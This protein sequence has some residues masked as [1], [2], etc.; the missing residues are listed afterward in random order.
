MFGFGGSN[1]S[2]T[3]TPTQPPT[4][5]FEDQVPTLREFLREYNRISE[6]C[7]NDCINDFSG[8][9]GVSSAEGLCVGF[10]LEKFLKV[11]QRISQRFQEHQMLMNE[12]QMIVGKKTGLFK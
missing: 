7:F 5:S 11:T 2:A 10:C 6:V 1:K 9:A 12:N 4:P 8:K 3:N